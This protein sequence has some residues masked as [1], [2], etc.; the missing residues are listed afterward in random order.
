MPHRTPSSS[1]GLFPSAASPQRVRWRFAFIRE[2]SKNLFGAYS[3][4]FV[5]PLGRLHLPQAR[6]LLLIRRGCFYA[7]M[8]IFSTLHQND[9]VQY[10]P[11]AAAAGVRLPYSIGTPLS[12]LSTLSTLGFHWGYIGILEKKVETTIWGSRFR[13]YS[14]LFIPNPL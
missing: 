12:N 4:S 13:T 1:G 8:T 2:G 14:F 5:Q 3:L 10:V 11:T 7:K 9:L 6:G